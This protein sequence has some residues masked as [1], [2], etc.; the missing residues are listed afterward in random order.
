MRRLV[1]LA[2]L[3]SCLPASVRA[4][5]IVASGDA[6]PTDYLSDLPPNFAT[7]GNQAFFSNVLG[8]GQQVAVLD[9]ANPSWSPELLAF[10]GSLPGVTA[11]LLSGPLD[12]AQLADVDLL[13]VYPNDALTADEILSVGSFID[14]GGSLFVMGDGV[15]VGTAYDVNP[16]VNAILV[17]IGSGMRLNEDDLD[18]GAQL[19][20]GDHIL[21]D[22]LSAGVTALSYVAASTVDGGT[23]LFLASTGAPFIAY[24]EILVP[25]PST[26]VLVLAGLGTALSS[27]GRNPRRL[28]GSGDQRPWR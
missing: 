28:G 9:S 17:G 3:L 1:L 8:S 18:S 27:S 20:L 14:A 11:S 23:P 19:A 6:T 5:V 7:V 13:R 12:G 24:E 21:A 25:E 26:L 15:G 22:P 2:A 4:G 10:Y 16:N